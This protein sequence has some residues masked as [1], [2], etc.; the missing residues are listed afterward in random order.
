MVVAGAEKLSPE[1]RDAF[2]LKFNVDLFEGYGA[3]E[4]TPVASVNIPDQLDDRYWH[5]QRGQK[6]GTVWS[7]T[8]WHSVSHR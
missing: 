8:P 4:T 6:T 3:T 2:K 5:V 7:T 1:V